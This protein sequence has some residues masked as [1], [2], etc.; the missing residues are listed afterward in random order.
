MDVEKDV[1]FYKDYAQ[2]LLKVRYGEKAQPLLDEISKL[3]LADLDFHNLT[4]GAKKQELGKE[5]YVR[6]LLDHLS[7]FSGNVKVWGEL[8][9]VYERSQK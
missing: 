1:N 9:E 4:L 7:S 3:D 8:A 2:L 6:L 5:E